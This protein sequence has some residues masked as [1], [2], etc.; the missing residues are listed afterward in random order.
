MPEQSPLEPFLDQ[1]AE[2]LSAYD[3]N[4]DKTLTGSPSSEDIAEL[5]NLMGRVDA[6]KKAYE[7]AKQEQGISEDEI[8]QALKKESEQV[9]PKHK[10]ILK[11]IEGMRKDIHL[12]H[13]I[14]D[15]TI[16]EERRKKVQASNIFK[17][18]KKKGA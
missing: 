18:K 2:I 13:S 5:M 14:I 10:Q 7:I 6:M 4:R 1:I 11:K 8:D 17:T 16:K 15:K 12:E 9:S 3:E